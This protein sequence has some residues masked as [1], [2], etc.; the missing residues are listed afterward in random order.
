MSLSEVRGRPVALVHSDKLGTESGVTTGHELT[1]QDLVDHEPLGLRAVVAGDLGVRVRGV[2][3]IEIEG[4][5]QWL[6]PGW[7][8]L[9]TGLRFVGV[10]DA[11]PAQRALVA[12]LA[13]AGVSALLFGVGV[14]FEEV[15]R[16]LVAAAE[17][18][19]MPLLTVPAQVPFFQV[20]DF[21]NQ[22]LLSADAYQLKRQLWL[23]NDLL[24][25]LS[26]AQPVTALVTRLGQ[27]IRGTAVLFE[28]SGRI[29]AATGEGPARL[30]WSEI[31]TRPSGTQ[32]FTVG[33][34]RVAARPVVLGGTGYWVAV[35][36]RSEG[37]LEDLAEPLLDS[38]QRLLGATRGAR[39]LRLDQERAEAAQLLVTLADGVTPERIGR[40]WER[41][42]VFRFRP[43]QPLRVLVAWP[44]PQ[45]EGGGA[46]ADDLLERAHGSGLPLLL[47]VLPDDGSGSVLHCLAADSAALE[48]WAAH[49]SRTHTVGLSE[50]LTDL[51]TLP[52]RLR[53]AEMAVHV[54]ARRQAFVRARPGGADV[55]GFGLVRFEDVDLAT[56][57]LSSRGTDEVAAK[58]SQQLGELLARQDLVETVVTYFA[59]GLDVQ[60][61]AEALFL[62][63]NSVRYRLRRAEEVLN[64]SL[65]STA[66]IANLH[67]ALQDQIA[68][69]S[70]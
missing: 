4:P 42:R 17:H 31:G 33:R 45:Q 70:T 51:L 66:I 10:A 14:P 48:A 26:E 49:L 65:A 22:S 57:L 61:T 23:Q 60:R 59:C 19:G 1:L 55:E 29:V 69:R 12:E 30:I 32:R 64:A 34:W 27:L 56:W 21:V 7:A 3:A 37:V 5:A 11:A 18:H 15:P 41:L 67:L 39:T 62:H 50:V 2:H 52:S 35:A 40:M 46:M 16:G 54:A 38:T 47:R 36:S 24:A 6:R 28:E 53:D 44:G 63:P 13:E 43:H 58:T 68:E 20:E 25:A 8:M 9:T